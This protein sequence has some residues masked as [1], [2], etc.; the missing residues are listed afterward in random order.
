M[1]HV[2]FH[3]GSLATQSTLSNRK[4]IVLFC[5]ALVLVSV[6]LPASSSAKPIGSYQ[7][8]FPAKGSP[9]D[10]KIR[11]TAKATKGG[12]SQIYD[13]TFNFT[14]GISEGLARDLI[15][16][17]LK[18]AGWNVSKSSTNGILITGHGN[19]PMKQVDIGDNKST[20]KV[21]LDGK[22]VKFGE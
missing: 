15:F 10:T 16:T 18:N 7:I 19:K 4:I 13:K 11:V 3:L 21:S 14:A 8:D 2:H 9:D 5:F 12:A 1:R 22:D 6:F 20:V 17:D